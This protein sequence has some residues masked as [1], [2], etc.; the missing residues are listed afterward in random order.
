MTPFMARFV[1]AFDTFTVF[2]RL[3][4]FGFAALFIWLTMLTGIPDHEDSGDFYCL[5]LGATVG[6]T[7][8]ASSQHLLMIYIG[9]EMASLPSYA[10]AGFLKGKRQSSEASS[11]KRSASI[12]ISTA[13]PRLPNPNFPFASRRQASS[14]VK[15]TPGSAR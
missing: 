10:L 14:M 4:L 11:R 6:M 5:L 9:V 7:L 2:L 13:R 12:P 15:R 1:P 3:F 8:M